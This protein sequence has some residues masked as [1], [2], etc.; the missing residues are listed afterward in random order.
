MSDK[1]NIFEISVFD[2]GAMLR[3]HAQTIMDSTIDL[4]KVD[5]DVLVPH[6]ER[7]RDIAFH[8]ANAIRTMREQTK[9]TE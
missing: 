7:M 2:M 9:T 8:L 4:S 5:P 1:P 3:G 6:C